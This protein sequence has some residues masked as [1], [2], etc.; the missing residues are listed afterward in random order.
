MKKLISL[1]IIAIIILL[2]S[3]GAKTAV[4][5]IELESDT[6]SSVDEIESTTNKG[7]KLYIIGNWWSVPE[8]EEGEHV[9]LS[10]SEDMTFKCWMSTPH[11]SYNY[12]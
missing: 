5:P 3:C 7:K 10:I 8:E 1:I 11:Y 6:V 2:T 9:Y 12:E 4:K